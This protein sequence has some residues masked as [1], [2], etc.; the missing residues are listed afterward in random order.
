MEAE[1]GGRRPE[2]GDTMGPIVAEEIA[3]RVILFNA[4]DEV[5]L[6]EVSVPG[7]PKFFITPGGRLDESDVS[8]VGA[9][10][11]E[12][13][14]ETGF[15]KFEVHSDVPLYSGSH[16]MKKGSGL[17][18]MTEHF[19]SACLSTEED[20]I[21]ESRQSL[22]PEEQELFVRQRWFSLAEL[23]SGEFII[24]PVNIAAFV[25]SFLDS[26]P[27]PDVD[28]SDPPEFAS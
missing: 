4:R 14:E 10:R 5:L 21:D 22:T 18:Q 23:E 3:V 7:K 24:V 20:D 25:K 2:A 11:R 1:H 15:Q 16:V 26:S 19:F 13:E 8:L 6:Q 27:L 17:V 28:F 12:L 9:V